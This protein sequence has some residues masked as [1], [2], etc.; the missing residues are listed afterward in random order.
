MVVYSERVARPDLSSN[1]RQ[2]AFE[3]GERLFQVGEE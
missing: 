3:E 1:G 2:V